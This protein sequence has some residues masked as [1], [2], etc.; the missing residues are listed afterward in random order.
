M[1][2][3]KNPR[4]RLLH[5]VDE[6]DGVSAALAGVTFEQYQT[7]FVLR[8]SVERA[9]QI[10]SEAVRALPESILDRYP[11]EP[12]H[13]IAAVGNI[14]RHEY[15]TVDDKRMWDI[16]TNHLPRLRPLILTMLADC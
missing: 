16:A 15:Q 7:S 9:V 14:L 1:A 11:D 8:R 6:I 12:W 2:A 5:I 10:V 3:S 4:A 13:A